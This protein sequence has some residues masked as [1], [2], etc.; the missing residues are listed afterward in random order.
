MI[1][2]NH[3]V[4]MFVE[5]YLSQAVVYFSIAT[6]LYWCVWKLGRRHFQ[7]SR[8][9]RTNELSPAQLSREVRNTLL[10][11]IVGTATAVLISIL[12]AVGVTKLTTDALSLG[13][14]MIM[15]TTVGLL[16]F[17]DAWFYW[18]HRLLHH[19]ALFRF[20]HAEH[21]RS[22][23]VDPFTSYSFHW[24]ESFL[25]GAWVLPATL[26]VPIYLPMLG[27]LQAI[28]LANNLMSHLGYEFF[29]R[30]LM[31]VPV[32]RWINTA[33]YHAL[34]HTSPSGNFGLMT[35]LWDR[36]LG[37]EVP[38]YEQA[39]EARDVTQKR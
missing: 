4:L 16:F 24:F 9:N 1:E 14:P 18:C 19:R 39:F 11:M 7:E 23:N 15:V 34:H 17:N 6:T 28:G 35:R 8:L 12:Y 27:L 37:T 3:P 10:T 26:L 29:P 31:K 20:V 25:Y 32:V 36:L 33:T 21:H 5:G 2:W 38:H 13:W 22:V 30:G